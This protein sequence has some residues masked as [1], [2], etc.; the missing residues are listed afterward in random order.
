MSDP[1]AFGRRDGV[2]MAGDN[3]V[4]FFSSGGHQDQH[5]DSIGASRTLY[6]LQNPDQQ[7]R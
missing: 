3:H 7:I 4:V 2:L 6:D 5:K 1:I